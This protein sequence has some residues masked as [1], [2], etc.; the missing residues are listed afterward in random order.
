M[1][2]PFFFLRIRSFNI[3]ILMAGALCAGSQ[4]L[5]ALVPEGNNNKTVRNRWCKS[6]DG[7]T[8]DCVNGCVVESKESRLMWKK[9]AFGT[10]VA[11]LEV[12]G[13]VFLHLAMKDNPVRPS[14]KFLAWLSYIS[15]V[16]ASMTYILVDG[17][18]PLD[19]LNE[20]DSYPPTE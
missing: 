1:K 13:A 16:S 11:S 20:V 10:G 19:S 4:N 3:A 9:Y 14:C 7:E 17:G 18:L 8:A 15:F 6:C 12:L 2:V 5:F